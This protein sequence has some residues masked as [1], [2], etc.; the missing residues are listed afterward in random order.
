VEDRIPVKHNHYVAVNLAWYLSTIISGLIAAFIIV[1][2]HSDSTGWIALVLEIGGAV[3]TILAIVSPAAVGIMLKK[4][5]DPAA[6]MTASAVLMLGHIL[7]ISGPFV[8]ATPVI[9]RYL[10][11]ARHNSGGY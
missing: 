3:L 5:N 11:V 10:A 7:I 6:A 8:L 2:T 4:M 1:Q 9:G